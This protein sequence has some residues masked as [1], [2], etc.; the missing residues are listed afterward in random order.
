MKEFPIYLHIWDLAHL[1][2]THRKLDLHYKLK[3]EDSI[4]KGFATNLE[5]TDRREYL[6]LN[7]LLPHSYTRTMQQE[8]LTAKSPSTI[9]CTCP[10]KNWVYPSF[11]GSG[12]LSPTISSKRCYLQA[13]QR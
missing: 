9:V 1:S 10:T 4:I 5:Q 6:P 11:S 3:L 2:L 12:P 7:Y 8:L 13:Y